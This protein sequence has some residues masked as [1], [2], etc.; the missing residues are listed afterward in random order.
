M[1]GYSLTHR[2]KRSALTQAATFATRRLI[3]FLTPGYELRAG[4]VMAISAMK[5]ETAALRHLHG[6]KTILCAVPGDDPTF[7]KY[8]WFDNRDYLLDLETVLKSCRSLEYLQIHIPD[9]AVNR[10]LTWL[11]ANASALL[12]KVPIVQLNVVLFNIDNIKGQNVRGLAAFGRTTV[13]TGHEAYSDAATRDLLGATL[14]RLSVCNGPENYTRSSYEQKEPLLIVS[15]D[16]HALKGEVLDRIARAC[17]ELKIQ[18]IEDLHY[19]EYLKLIRRAKWS[20]TFGE[21]LDGYFA[22]PVCSGGVAFA[23]FNDR[24]F[25]PGFAELETVYPSWEVLMERMPVDLRRLDNRPA[26]ERG[27]RQT[28]DLIGGLYSTERFRENLQKF[29]REE[30]TFP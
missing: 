27:W 9:Y 16:G 23:V 15:P 1:G 3:V 29:Y 8:S 22:E 30:Y 5:R 17:P 21:G 13:T 18:V 4:G 10:V 14:H 24:Y 25:T 2:L 20:L 7:F 11:S 26:Y 28:Y 19:N 12:R 6:A